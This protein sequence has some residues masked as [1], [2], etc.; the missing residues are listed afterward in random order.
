MRR[1]NQ[2]QSEQ[3]AAK[4][5]RIMEFH[6]SPLSSSFDVFGAELGPPKFVKW[7]TLPADRLTS[8]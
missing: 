6:V 3:N 7:G 4:D 8:R 1:K 5:N 2:E